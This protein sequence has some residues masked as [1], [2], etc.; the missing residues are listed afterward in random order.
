MPCNLLYEDLW[1]LP[2][3]ELDDAARSQLREDLDI[4][5]SDLIDWTITDS[6]H[7]WYELFFTPKS[8]SD[9][10]AK[11]SCDLFMRIIDYFEEHEWISK[12]QTM[13][14]PMCGIG[15]FLMMGALRGYNTIGVEI[16][17]IF[18]QDMMGYDRTEEHPDDLFFGE[19][20]HEQG[21]IDK[22]YAVT[23][24]V[25]NIGN[26]EVYNGDS[27][28]I[29]S[30]IGKDFA[31]FCVFSP[32]YTRTAEHS[33]K[34]IE[35]LPD[36]VKGKPFQYKSKYNLALMN[37]KSGDFSYY[38]GKIATQLYFALHVGSHVAII[39]RDFIEEGSVIS[40][41]NMMIDLMIHKGFE[42]IETK[43]AD[44]PHVSFFKWNNWLKM[45]RP[46]LLPLIT[47][48]HVTIF[49]RKDGWR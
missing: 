43:I 19:T 2:Y 46:K 4:Q 34:Q 41:E 48:E 38:F 40:M 13:L 26:I 14:D 31:D 33:E 35:A 36:K 25:K 44:L 12:G 30:F 6:N 21:N 15:S 37:Y 24:D 27:R 20:S 45:H 49:K 47:W 3:E 28:G 10:Q 39:T 23:K 16:E 8:L 17:E 5:K 29:N 22:F 18:Y 1:H 32:P 11:N 9:H 42:H 7:K